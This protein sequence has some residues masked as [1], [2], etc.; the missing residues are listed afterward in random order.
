[1]RDG[2]LAVDGG[3]EE[4]LESAGPIGALDGV[5]TVYGSPILYLLEVEIDVASGRGY[6]VFFDGAEY[7]VDFE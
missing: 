4:L 6:G 7:D 3:S 2:V 5:D 1:M